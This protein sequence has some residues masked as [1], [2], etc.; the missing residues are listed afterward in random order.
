[1]I[2][3]DRTYLLISE[4]YII[5]LQKGSLMSTIVSI[6]PHSTCNVVRTIQVGGHY[7][8]S[9][10]MYAIIDEYDYAQ[11]RQYRWY[12]QFSGHRYYARR[13][14]II[15]GKLYRQ[16]MHDLIMRCIG[17]DHDNGNGL[18]N[19]RVN[20][21][22]AN[23]SQNGGNEIKGTGTSSQYKG[24]YWHKL[25]QK[26][27]AQIDINRHHMYL[28]IYVDEIDAARAYDSAAIKYFG[29]YAN[30]NL[31]EVVSYTTYH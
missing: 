9:K 15:D 25:R 8:N 19:R 23:Q 14:W 7:L 27:V 11:I 5:N 4:Q 2:L 17:V 22:V 24:V 10:K 20:L 18:D 28:G 30:V 16:Y 6:A 21:R 1:M 3:A 12:V 31:K 26:W 13:Q 29:R